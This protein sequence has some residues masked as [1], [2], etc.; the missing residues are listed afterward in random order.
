MK[1]PCVSKH[2]E[3]G[4]KEDFIYQPIS[5]CISLMANDLVPVGE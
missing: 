1:Q 5:A 3:E 4:G 2:W